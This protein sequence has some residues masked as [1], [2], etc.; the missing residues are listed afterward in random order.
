LFREPLAYQSI[1]PFLEGIASRFDYTEINSAVKSSPEFEVEVRRAGY[2]RPLWGRRCPMTIDVDIEETKISRLWKRSIRKAINKGLADA[3]I[4]S[5]PSERDCSLFF[6]MFSEMKER[7]GI[8]H[9]PSIPEL[10]E[11]LSDSSMKLFV[12]ND[13]KGIVAGRIVWVHK[14][15]AYDVYAANSNRARTCSASYK[16]M[17]D[18]FNY[19]KNEGVKKFDFGRIGPGKTSLDSVFTFKRGSGGEMISYN[20]EWVHSKSLLKSIG[21]VGYL[22]LVKKQQRW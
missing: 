2:L 15:R 1:M 11:L 10:C 14:D 8:G 5:Q 9:T 3:R 17:F 7:K 21:V 18:I 12:I 4:I 22:A 20:G 16:L 19:L 6:S 13:S